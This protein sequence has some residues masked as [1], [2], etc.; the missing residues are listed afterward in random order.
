MDY[1]IYL[2][3]QKEHRIIK[4]KIDDDIKIKELFLDTFS[5]DKYFS[6]NLD[7]LDNLDK[8]YF[9]KDNVLVN[10]NDKAFDIVIVDKNNSPIKENIINIQCHIKTCGGGV[11]E[12]IIDPVIGFVLMVFDPIVKPIDAIGK[13]F[14]FLIKSIF[15]L[16]KFVI[17]FVWFL[18]WVFLDLLNPVNFI[19]DFYNSIILITLTICRVPFELIVASFKIC[20]NIV[21][22]WMQGFWGWDMSSLTKADKNSLYFKSFNRKAGQKIYYTQ[23]NTIP[24]S[25]IIGT[26]LCPPMGVFMDLGTSGW[27]NIIVC[28]LLTLLFYLPGLCYALLIIYS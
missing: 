26:I 7:N 2:Q 8:L 19:A 13:A 12:D 22:G 21:G 14:I 3:F 17:W 9:I 10:S 11:L 5:D 15:W 4:K 25:I 1:T 6:D 20:I 27:L 18:T 28:C 23:Q 24:F 16:F